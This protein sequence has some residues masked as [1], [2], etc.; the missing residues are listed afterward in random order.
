MLCKTKIFPQQKHFLLSE[1]LIIAMLA[2]M[3]LAAKVV[4]VPLAHLIT[5]PPFYSRRRTRGRIFFMLF[6]LLAA[7]IT[8][9]RGGAALLVS[10]IQAVLV[11]ISGTFG[12]H[13]G[14]ASLFTYSAA[15]IGAELVFLLS[16]HRG[17]CCAPLLFFL[18]G[19]GG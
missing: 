10:L 1:Y 6:L 11:T 14:A 16:G 12:S 18:G 8:Q 3:G 17:G 19:D 7:A 15:G 2:A 4:I 5:G 13:G 9:K